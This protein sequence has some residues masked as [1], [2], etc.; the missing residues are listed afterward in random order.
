MPLTKGAFSHKASSMHWIMEAQEK[1]PPKR[2]RKL[3]VVINA[4]Q[5]DGTDTCAD[6]IDLLGANVRWVPVRTLE[7][8]THE[9]WVTISHGDYVIKGV[10]NDFYP[11]K[12]DIFV[13][14][15]ESVEE[16]DGE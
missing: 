10:S 3:P 13:K 16:D 14:T 7:I 9:G 15:Y 8:E 12:P 5:F 11:C 1:Y 2:W 6:A 4:I